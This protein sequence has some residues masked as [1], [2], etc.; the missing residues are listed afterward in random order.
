MVCG[1]TT[2]LPMNRP[3]R[4]QARRPGRQG[5]C[6]GAPGPGTAVIGLRQVHAQD[7][8]WS[9]WN[10]GSEGDDGPWWPGRPA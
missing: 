4:R 6:P 1:S 10:L 5:W 9:R 3:A 8:P 7:G 2:K